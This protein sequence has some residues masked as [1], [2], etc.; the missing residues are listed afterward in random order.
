MTNVDASEHDAH[1]LA[2]ERK[3]RFCGGWLAA[4]DRV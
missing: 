1:L 4:S 2:T 3:R